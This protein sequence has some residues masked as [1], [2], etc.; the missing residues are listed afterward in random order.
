MPLRKNTKKNI[1]LF[2]LLIYV[3][4][5]FLSNAG[6]TLCFGTEQNRHIG[7]HALSYDS[8][9]DS[10]NYNLTKIDKSFNRYQNKLDCSNFQMELNKVPLMTSNKIITELSLSGFYKDFYLYK[11][12]HDKNNWK[13]YKD[14]LSFRHLNELKT[15]ILII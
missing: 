5:S 15:I 6:A 12:K 3:L 9:T 11:A 13:I 7:I 2:C 14:L 10:K 4:F 1:T 8:C